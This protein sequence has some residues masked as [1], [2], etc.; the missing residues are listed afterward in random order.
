MSLYGSQYVSKQ[1]VVECFKCGGGVRVEGLIEDGWF[2]ICPRCYPERILVQK[3]AGVLLLLP[4]NAR[5]ID[6]PSSLVAAG[7]PDHE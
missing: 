2:Y 5:V 7:A 3:V 4:E 6:L 1:M